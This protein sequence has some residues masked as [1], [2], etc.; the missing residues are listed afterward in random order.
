MNEDLKG[1]TCIRRKV[2]VGKENY[3]LAIGKNFIHVTIPREND[4]D[5]KHERLAMEMVCQEINTIRGGMDE[6]WQGE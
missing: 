2:I 4:P 6:R 3:Y 1:E 5:R